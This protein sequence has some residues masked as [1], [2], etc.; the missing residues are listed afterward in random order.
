MMRAAY[1]WISVLLLAAIGTAYVFWHPIAWLLVLAVP[2]ILIGLYDINSR[3]NVLRNYPVIGHLRYMMEFISPEIRQYF[4]ETNQSGRPFNREMRTLIYRRSKGDGDTLPFGTQ[5]DITVQGY[6]FAYHSLAPRVPPEETARVTVGGPQCS[7]PYDA[8]RLNVSGMSFGALSGNAILA[9]NRG[10]L[11]GGFAHNT[12]EGG[13][14]RYHLR[15]G[16]DIIWQIGTGY[17]GCRTPDGGFDPEQFREKAQLD[18]VKMVEIKLSQ[19]AKPSHG[20]VLP[21]V[22]VN[23][24]IATARGVAPGEDCISPPAHS[25]FASPE[26]L[27]EF[28]ARLREMS[29]GKPVG[30]KLCLGI[31][32]EFLAICKAMRSTGVLPDFITVDGAEGGTGAAPVEFTDNLGTP[33]NEGLAYVHSAL[34][35]AGL[36]E[37]IRLIASGKVATGFDMVI[38]HALGAE[39]CNVAR[40][41]MFSIGCIQAL[42]CNTNTCPTGITTQDP[43]R[44][45]ALDVETKHVRVRNLHDATLGSFLDLTGALGHDDPDRLTPDLIWHRRTDG[46]AVTYAEIYSFLRPNQLLEGGSLPADWER[47]W[48]RADAGSFRPAA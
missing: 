36:R 17:F 6:D 10:A 44:S 40:P 37:N 34:T 8:S 20:G 27:L 46:P 29:G 23:R 39:L 30:F 21:G 43:R 25:E 7:R 47:D 45:R 24:E 22:K 4:V 19:G 2:Y 12:G 42:R 15:H 13:L 26:G 18:A 35:G 33:I 9:L 32:S 16:G 1:Y 3:H 41:M 5:Q 28:V 14:S 48:R 38:K 31:R 11:L